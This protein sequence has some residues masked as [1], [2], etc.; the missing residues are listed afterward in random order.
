MSGYGMDEDVQ[1]SREVGFDEHLVKPVDVPQ[2]LEAIGRVL[3][4]KSQVTDE[5]GG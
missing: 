5:K 2:L 3:E 4:R 1:R